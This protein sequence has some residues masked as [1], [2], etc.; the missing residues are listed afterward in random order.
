MKKLLFVLFISM[1]LVAC[2]CP[3]EEESKRNASSKTMVF[4]HR[5]S[6]G[7]VVDGLIENTLPSVSEVLKYADGT[8]VDIQMSKSNTIWLYHDD[9]FKHLCPES[10]KLIESGG[11]NCILNTP[12]EIIEQ[13]QICREGVKERIYTLEELFEV[14]TDYNHKMASLD[15][16]G[17]FN[18]SCVQY[19][20]VSE[21]YQKDLAIELFRLV[22]K[23]DLNQQIIAETNYT[24]THEKLKELDPNFLC[25]Y[26]SYDN[27]SK[28]VDKAIA[29]N[30][31]GITMN[32][33]DN[34]FNLENFNK[35]KDQKLDIQFWT[36]NSKDDAIKAL[37][38]APYSIQVGNI[39][40]VKELSTTSS[41]QGNR[42]QLF[43]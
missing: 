3:C 2:D 34:S 7:G 9:L 37:K 6:G 27:H 10:K 31:D 35:A 33:N 1:A 28:G 26:M 16:K 41:S 13:L 40:L 17:Y 24:K 36:V 42:S 4:G 29:T 21:E 5:G 43:R 12:D 8:E 14:L 19:N 38:F 25:H 32:I 11:Y 30:V 22:E 15:I 23:F 39:K 18:T 20:N